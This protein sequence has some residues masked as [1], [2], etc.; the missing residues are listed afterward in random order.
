MTVVTLVL[1]A[2]IV[3]AQA[4]SIVPTPC[5]N[6][7]CIKGSGLKTYSVKITG[8]RDPQWNHYC[9]NDTCEALVY[10]GTKER[11]R[12]TG[13]GQNQYGDPSP[14]SQIYPLPQLKRE[15]PIVEARLILDATID[16]GY[17][18]PNEPPYVVSFYVEHQLVGDRIQV[19]GLLRNPKHLPGPVP[20]DMNFRKFTFEL[21][22]PAL[23]LLNTVN[24]I[25]TDLVTP[26]W[27]CIDESWLE[28]DLCDQKCTCHADSLSGHW[29]S[30]WCD[31]C[32][33]GWTGQYCNEPVPPAP[34]GN[35]GLVAAV[36]IFV[37]ATVGLSVAL[38]IIIRKHRSLPSQVQEKQGLAS[39]SA[40]GGLA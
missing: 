17:D 15:D 33:A 1:L 23:S 30:Q 24:N 35:G 18:F 27:L 32:A 37:L 13:Q 5:T 38:F 10:G 6:Y 21:P 16:S 4:H 2:C 25:T 14:Y 11:G 12:G 34:S 29:Q 19:R 28:V 22:A 39:S 20:P 31:K 40:Y 9:P 26:G 8:M 36:V 3:A 7:G